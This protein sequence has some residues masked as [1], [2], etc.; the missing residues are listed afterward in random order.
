MN[1]QNIT[2]RTVDDLYNWFAGIHDYLRPTISQVR[3]VMAD[4]IRSNCGYS[5]E[6]GKPGTLRA[7]RGVV[8]G[9]IIIF[10][11]DALDQA[12]TETMKQGFKF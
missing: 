4:A 7:N 10:D 3:D 6:A 5:M 8:S 1:T 9:Q 12:Y 11:K 2:I